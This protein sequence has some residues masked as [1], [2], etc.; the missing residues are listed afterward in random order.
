MVSFRSHLAAA[1]WRGAPRF[2]AC[3]TGV[4][5]LFFGAVTCSRAAETNNVLDSW[6]S[7]QTNFHTFTAQVI[8]TRT[9]KVLSEP[10]VSTGK[11]WIAM[12]DRFRW[13]IGQPAQTIALRQPDTLFII[14]PRLKRIEKY[15]LTGAQPGQWRDVLALLDA[16]FPKSRAIMEAQFRVLSIIQTNADWQVALQPRSALA[17]SLMGEMD[18]CV[19]TNDFSLSA[20][21]M[22]FADGSRMRNDFTNIILNP[23]LPEGCFDLN[24]APDSTVVEPLRQ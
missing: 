10:L 6:F 21:E 22:R 24:P 23:V 20:T 11:V 8:Q 9:L 19:R 16:S 18:I 17:R 1:R 13:E 5:I 12:P 4:V 14:Y 15:P 7:A 3:L 2:R